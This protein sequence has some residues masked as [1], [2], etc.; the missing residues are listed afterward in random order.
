[1]SVDGDRFF[2]ISSLLLDVRECVRDARHQR[3][4]E[5][6][7]KST[8]AKARRNKKS[9]EQV[10]KGTL[11]SWSFRVP[12]HNQCYPTSAIYYILCTVL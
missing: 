7:E 11:K 1:M 5:E 2:F 9:E 3:Q 4:C 6:E 10:G 8:D 12:R